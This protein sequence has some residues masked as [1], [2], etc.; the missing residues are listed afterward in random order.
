MRAHWP[1]GRLLGSRAV[2]YSRG[3]HYEAGDLL[4]APDSPVRIRTVI[5]DDSYAVREGVEATLAHEPDIEVVRVCSDANELTAL[6][7]AE[8]PTGV[9]ADIRSPP[10]VYA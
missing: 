10:S 9:T 8:H 1:T 3:E 6:V 7:A 5:A 4:G 2:T